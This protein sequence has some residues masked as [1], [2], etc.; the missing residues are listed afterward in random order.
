MSLFHLCN[1]NAYYFYGKYVKDLTVFQANLFSQS[2]YFKS[3]I[4]NCFNINMAVPKV[5]TMTA[6]N[7]GA[8]LLP[9]TTCLNPGATVV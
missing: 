1:D 4:Q 7:A 9:P 8:T 2:K 5:S 3:L 6:N